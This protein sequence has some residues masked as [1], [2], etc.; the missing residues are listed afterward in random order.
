[1]QPRYTN[2]ENGGSASKAVSAALITLV[3]GANGPDRSA[4]PILRSPRFQGFKV[5][6]F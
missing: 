2:Y 6:E 3:V 5:E 4:L 1:M